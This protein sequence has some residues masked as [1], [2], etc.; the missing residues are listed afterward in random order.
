MLKFHKILGMPDV[1][2]WTRTSAPN[3]ARPGLW[4]E[5]DLCRMFISI[6]RDRVILALQH[7]YL[8]FVNIPRKNRGPLSV[9]ISKDGNRKRDFVGSGSRE[10]D[11]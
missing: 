7:L 10:F 2:H 4:L 6:P 9:S 1:L 5:L 8:K 3:L 11:N